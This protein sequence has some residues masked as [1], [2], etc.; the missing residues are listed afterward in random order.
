MSPQSLLQY[1]QQQLGRREVAKRLRVT[2]ETV[3]AWL[4]DP[5]E[6]PNGKRIALADLVQE[7]T[8]PGHKRTPR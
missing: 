1:V 4:H 2:E 7:L 8:D 5:A 3:D 6:M